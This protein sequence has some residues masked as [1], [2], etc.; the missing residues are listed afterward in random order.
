VHFHGPKPAAVRKYLADP[1]HKL[2]PSWRELLDRGGPAYQA[3]LWEW[4]RY[5][6]L[7]DVATGPADPVR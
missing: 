2:L 5:R 3:F 6:A 4:T 7:A 1:G